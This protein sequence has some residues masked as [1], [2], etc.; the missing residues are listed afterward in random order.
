MVIAHELSHQWFGNLVTMK[1][2]DDLWLN[3]SFASIMEHMALDAIHPDW[4]QWEQYVAS[5][6]ISTSSRDVYSDIQ[7]VAVT[8][9]DPDLIETLFDPGIVYAKGG[10]LLKMLRDYIGDD[11]FRSGLQKYFKEFAY[12]N[13]SRE[14][15]WAK[16]SESSKEDISALMTPWLE[17]PGMPVLNVTPKDKQLVI[18]Q[19][20]FLLDG[21]DKTSQWPVPLLTNNDSV[22]LLLDKKYDEFTIKEPANT[23]LNIKASGHYFTHYQNDD[24]REWIAKQIATQ[25]MPTEARINTLN[26]LYMLSRGNIASIVDGLDIIISCDEEPRDSVWAIMGRI[27]GASVQLTDGNKTAE[28]HL[29]RIKLRLARYWYEKLGWDDKKNDDPNTK[30]LRHT[31][32]AYVLGGEDKNALQKAL[33]QYEDNKDKLNNIHAEHRGSILVSSVKQKGKPV[34]DNLLAQFSDASSDLQLDITAALAS[35]RDKKMASHIIGKALGDNGFVRPQDIARWIAY[36]MRNFYTRDVMW[37]F[38]QDNWEWIEEKLGHSKSFDY[39]PAY[40]SSVMNTEAWLL[41]YEEFFAD[42]KQI[43]ALQRDIEVGTADIKARIA[44]R[45]REEDKILRWLES[46]S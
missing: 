24:H 25:S 33:Q 44:W 15:L 35:T 30:Q 18:S 27:I 37:Q 34:I 19:Q 39:I 20:R 41:K 32:I 16:I 2:W 5:D 28:E 46:H 38:L 29:K 14:D 12:Q 40:T 21:Q 10:R 7:P 4:H 23:V 1:W 3:E 6:V 31:A 22:H 45:Q 13:T 8:V 42:K 36:F 9:T 26:D 17:K 11:A 43:K